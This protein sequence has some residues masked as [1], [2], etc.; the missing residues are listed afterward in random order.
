M[1]ANTHRHRRHRNTPV[2]GVAVDFQWRN[3]ASVSWRRSELMRSAFIWCP[4]QG[5]LSSS[6]CLPV[7]PH[8]EFRSCTPPRGRPGWLR[9]MENRQ[10]SAMREV[11]GMTGGDAEE[12]S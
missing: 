8:L 9:V 2:V 10:R 11:E 4:D 1:V 7:S 12:S 6:R 5:E 3:E